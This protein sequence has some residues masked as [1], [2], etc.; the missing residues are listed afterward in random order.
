MTTVVLTRPLS[1]SERLAAVLAADGIDTVVMPIMT[2]SALPVN[3]LAPPPALG[4]HAI[5]V[6]VTGGTRFGMTMARRKQRAV[7][8]TV[9][10]NISPSRKCKCQS[11]GVVMVNVLFSLLMK[12]SL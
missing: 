5:C 11:S 12:I 4:Q 2:I 6:F 1:D 9:S 7:A 3:E 8:G 10:A